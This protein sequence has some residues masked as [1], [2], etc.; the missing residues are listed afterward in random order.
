MLYRCRTGQSVESVAAATTADRDECEDE[1]EDEGGVWA[2]P[3]TVNSGGE[4]T[5]ERGPHASGGNRNLA[6][7]HHIW[8]VSSPTPPAAVYRT[9]RRRDRSIYQPRQS[10]PCK[11]V[12][13][14][15]E[16]ERL[17]NVVS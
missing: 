15:E 3:A 14:E 6:R 9:P 17:S 12:H 5:P 8:V 4:A 16:C 1:D 2:A 13:T 7:T 11:G 10:K